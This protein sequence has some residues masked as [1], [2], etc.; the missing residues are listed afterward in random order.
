VQLDI[1]NKGYWTYWS[2]WHK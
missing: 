2:S 1:A